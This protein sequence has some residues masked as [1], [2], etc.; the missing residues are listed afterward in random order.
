MPFLIGGYRWLGGGTSGGFLST[1]KGLYGLNVLPA[2]KEKRSGLFHQLVQLRGSGDQKEEGGTRLRA[3]SSQTSKHGDRLLIITF[4]SH[5]DISSPTFI[6]G[7]T[8]RKSLKSITS[9]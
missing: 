9:I 1:G 7:H 3:V 2:L 4:R 6:R 5:T 8:R